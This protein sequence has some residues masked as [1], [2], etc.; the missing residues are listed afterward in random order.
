MMDQPVIVRLFAMGQPINGKIVKYNTLK[1]NAQDVAKL[2]FRDI[3]V[4]IFFRQFS[5]PLTDTK[6]TR[7][8]FFC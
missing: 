8:F 7:I 4:I 3:Q 2:L 1:P 5:K 6:C